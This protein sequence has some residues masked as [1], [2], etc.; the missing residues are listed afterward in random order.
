MNLML[1]SVVAVFKP[2]VTVMMM[3]WIIKKRYEIHVG[4]I[5]AA[6]KHYSV[7]YVEEEGT[8]VNGMASC[9]CGAIGA[10]GITAEAVE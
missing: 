7:G 6:T 10:V 8:V 5:P 9:S 2:P 1:T 4:P 3:S